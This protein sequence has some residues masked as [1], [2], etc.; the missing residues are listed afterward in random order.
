MPAFEHILYAVER[1][2]ARITLNRPAKRNALWVAVSASPCTCVL[3]CTNATHAVSPRDPPNW[4]QKLMV[5]PPAAS[6]SGGKAL[7]AVFMIN[8]FVKLM[9]NRLMMKNSMIDKAGVFTS[10]TLIGAVPAANRAKP[11]IIPICGGIVSASLPVNGRAT[12]TNSA[13]GNMT[14]AAS[15]GVMPWINC[16]NTGTP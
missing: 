2:R 4:R 10:A 15:S 3:V 12:T 13:D 8:G 6:L 9:P 11:I 1:G 16:T 7:S 14:N 5:P